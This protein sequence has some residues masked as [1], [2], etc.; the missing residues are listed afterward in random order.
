M[1]DALDLQP[2]PPTPAPQPA[3]P[4]VPVTAWWRRSVPVAVVAGLVAAWLVPLGTQLLH[5]DWLLPPLVLLG[6]ASL[7]RTRGSLLDR[8]LLALLLL[9]AA[10]AAAGVVLTIW[11]WH[12]QPVPVAGTA[13]SALVLLAA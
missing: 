12:L 8:L 5:V 13:L 3:S 4:A 10:T 11:P 6:V 9:L 2:A 1:R 7:L